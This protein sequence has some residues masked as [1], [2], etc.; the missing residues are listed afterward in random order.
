M[1]WITGATSGIGEDIAK[2]VAK[3]GAKLIVSG[4]NQQKLEELKEGLD[5]EVAT[6][7]FDLAQREQVQ[8]AL[9][10]VNSFFGKVDVLFNNGGISQRSHGADTSEEVERQIMEVNYFANIALTKGLLPQWRERGE[11]YACIIGSM[12]SLFGFFYRTSYGASKHALKGYYESL[13]FEEEP[14]GVHV[15]LVYPGFVNTPISKNSL[16]GDGGKYNK[17]DDAQ[18][19]GM[20]PELVVRQIVEGVENKKR[21]LV[22]ARKERMAYLLHRLSFNLFFKVL[23]GQKPY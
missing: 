7:P 5:T 9:Q 15:T 4:R 18:A 20:N 1:V 2:L 13:M 10:Q 17:L 22:I 19:T 3:K 14:N 11:G 23:K 12:T 6:L 21:T 8:Q 16:N